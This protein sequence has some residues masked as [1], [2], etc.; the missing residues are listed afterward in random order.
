MLAVTSKWVTLQEGPPS[1]IL[2]V[3]AELE[4]HGIPT[5]VPAMMTKMADPMIT[6]G[7]CFDWSLQV[8]ESALVAARELLRARAEF[9]REALDETDVE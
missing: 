5:F 9:G 3:Q 6:G 8:P 7:N 2:V 1:A 4:A